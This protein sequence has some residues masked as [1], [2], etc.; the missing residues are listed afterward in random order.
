MDGGK[1]P[2]GSWDL[3]DKMDIKPSI[4]PRH[5]SINK[6]ICQAMISPGWD[7]GVGLA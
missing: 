7:N 1:L 4:N 2:I 6:S 5:G 3:I